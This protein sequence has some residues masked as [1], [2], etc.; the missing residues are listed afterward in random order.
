MTY[1]GV[2]FHLSGLHS[3]A[4]GE[5]QNVVYYLYIFVGIVAIG[6]LALI[7]YN[8]HHSKKN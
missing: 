5:K 4:S 3:Y 2:N 6:I 8:K 1:V 7:K